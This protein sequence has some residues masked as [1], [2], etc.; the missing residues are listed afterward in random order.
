MLLTGIQGYRN[1]NTW[2][3]DPIRALQAGVIVKEIKEKNLLEN[4][5]ITGQYLKNG[6]LDLQKRYPQL[7]SNVRGLGTFLALD[8]PS[9]A[10]QGQMLSTLRQ[11][12]V[13][14]TG[15]GSQSVRFRPAL[16][17]APKHASQLLNIFEDSLKVINK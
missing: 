12:G 14:A 5:N 16:V 3:G 2:L 13:E 17:F 10:K 15:S 4:V 9:S 7:V 8:L 11:K 6:L 1:F